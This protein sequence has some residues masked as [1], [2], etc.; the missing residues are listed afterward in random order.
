M[1]LS[2]KSEE[3]EPEQENK[4]IKKSLK[5]RLFAKTT[6]VFG[7]VML[8]AGLFG[9]TVGDY[10]ER[11]YAFFLAMTGFILILACFCRNLE[12]MNKKEKNKKENLPKSEAR[13]D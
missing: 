13:R 5:A 4:E 3:F 7:A 9:V 6:E 1:T 10:Q 2:E 12:S 11:I 8:L